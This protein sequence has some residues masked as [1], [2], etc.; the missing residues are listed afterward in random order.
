MLHAQP[1]CAALK[2]YFEPVAV[3][4][5]YTCGNP[6]IGEHEMQ[7]VFP[8]RL[9]SMLVL[10]KTARCVLFLVSR[11]AIFSCS[12]GPGQ[13]RLDVISAGPNIWVTDFSRV[14]CVLF[15]ASPLASIFVTLSKTMEH[16]QRAR[17]Y[18][19]TPGPARL[20]VFSAGPNI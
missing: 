10:T 3:I 15:C 19:P 1:A 18:S 11:W 20:H 16:V 17:Q 8:W 2:H 6:K 14:R 4:L 12:N 5:D 9:V 7:K 13:A